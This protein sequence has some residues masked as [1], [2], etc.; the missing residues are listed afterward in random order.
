LG[1]R[2]AAQQANRADAYALCASAPLIGAF[3]S[4]FFGTMN[5]LV[6]NA[7][8]AKLQKLGAIC[9]GLQT[10]EDYPMTRLTTLKS[11]C[12]DRQAA[13]PFALHVATLAAAEATR[14]ARPRHRKLSAW[15][16]HNAPMVKAVGG[17]ERDVKRSTASKKL[18]LSEALASVQA[19]NH[20]Y[21]PS[22]WGQGR[23]IKNRPAL[24]VENR[25][26]GVVRDG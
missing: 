5:R 15:R 9:A 21:Q 10:G 14:H 1:N 16:Q 2:V 20:A 23:I 12:A 11:R 22:R 3:A 19:I 13:T 26:R 18:A 4:F 8:L 24:I 7:T 25:V 17:L 6:E